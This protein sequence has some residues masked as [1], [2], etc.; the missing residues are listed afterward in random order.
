V[1]CEVMSS[2]AASHQSRSLS[3]IPSRAVSVSELGVMEARPVQFLIMQVAG[4][5]VIVFA[6]CGC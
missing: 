6:Q 4:F 1:K 2:A 5:A 3:D